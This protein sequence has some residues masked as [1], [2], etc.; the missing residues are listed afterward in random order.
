MKVIKC[1]SAFVLALLL[2]SLT[3]TAMAAETTGTQDESGRTV[4]E[5]IDDALITTKVKAAFVDDPKLSAFAINV[6]THEGKVQ[7]SGFVDSPE[8]ISRAAEVAQ[9]VEGVKS[10]TNS[11]QLKNPL[12]K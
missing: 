6:D 8:N 9:K 12:S 5:V 2:T 1:C 4:G 11:L 10:V 3:G 7:L